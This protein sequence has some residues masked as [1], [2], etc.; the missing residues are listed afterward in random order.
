MQTID[1][2][3]KSFILTQMLWIDDVPYLSLSLVSIQFSKKS[4]VHDNLLVQ[5]WVINYTLKSFNSNVNIEISCFSDG[6]DFVTRNYTCK[7]TLVAILIL[8]IKLIWLLLC[9]F[10]FTFSS[11]FLLLRRLGQK[12][13][14]VCIACAFH[15]SFGFYLN[16]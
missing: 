12:T 6:L 7:N 11:T 13:S 15:R 5:F 16:N 2:T 8:Q 4:N 3:L 9:K 1:D 14:T 10:H